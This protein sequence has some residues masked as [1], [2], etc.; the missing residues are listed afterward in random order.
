MRH[1]NTTEVHIGTFMVESGNLS[2]KDPCYERGYECA[3]KNGIWTAYV[4]R[5]EYR[6]YSLEAYIE[7]TNV[8]EQVVEEAG[9]DSGQMG[10]YDLDKS[11]DTS[12]TDY[13]RICNITLGA[14]RSGI[15]GRYG[16]VSSTAYG[17]GTYPVSVKKSASTGAIVYVR[18]D[19]DPAEYEDYYDEDGTFLLR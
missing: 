1:N 19:F 7:D 9:V 2:I 3:A 4:T 11:R 16:V 6:V 15:I 13:D 5:D 14:G 10:I 18:I 8:T 12:D 17:D